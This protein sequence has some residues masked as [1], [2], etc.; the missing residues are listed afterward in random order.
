VIV[1]DVATGRERHRTNL[2]AVSDPRI[3][4]QIVCPRRGLFISLRSRGEV[5]VWDLVN[6][7]LVGNVEAHKAEIVG[8]AVSPDETHFATLGLDNKLKVWS[9]VGKRPSP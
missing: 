9:L 8:L 6:N 4:Y 3:W 1:Y 7:R 2:T 5:V